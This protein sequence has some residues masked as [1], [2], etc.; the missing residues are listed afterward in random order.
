LF[1]AGRWPVTIYPG[2]LRLTLTFVVPLAFA[3]TVP[4]EGL[5][6]RLTWGTLLLTVIV[7]GVMLLLTRLAWQYGVRN[8]SGASA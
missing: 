4:A 3:I 5:T 7:T 1:Q 2:W 8:Y 6:S